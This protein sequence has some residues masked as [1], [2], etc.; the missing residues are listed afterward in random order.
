MAI[1]QYELKR[2][3]MAADMNNQ[4]DCF[5]LMKQFPN[6]TLTFGEHNNRFNLNLKNLR[7]KAESEKAETFSTSTGRCD[8][9]MLVDN[10]L[11]YPE[12]RLKSSFYNMYKEI[13]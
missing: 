5:E 8:D 13:D 1:K 4:E 2:K 7:K 10:G 3:V 9:Y 6:A 11:E 12:L